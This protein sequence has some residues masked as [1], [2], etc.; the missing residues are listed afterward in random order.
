MS[1]QTEKTSKQFWERFWQKV[2][3][4]E[5]VNYSFKND[6][7]VGETLKAHIPNGA[8]N[9][10]MA[11]IG[12][13]PGKWL[14]F[15]YEK[16]SYIVTGYEYLEIAAKKTEENLLLNNVPHDKFNIIVQDFTRLKGFQKQ[17]V[18]FSTGFIEH[19][20]DYE[21]ILE[22]Q[23]D[24]LNNDGYLIIGVPSFRYVNYLIQ[25]M[26]DPY[27]SDKVLPSHN[28]SAMKKANLLKFARTHNLE[29]IFCEFLGGY[30][31]ALFNFD[32]VQHC[33]IRFTL[34]ALNALLSSRMFGFVNSSFVS[35]FLFSIFKKPTKITSNSTS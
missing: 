12:C 14:V 34:K 29:V 35:G 23:L 4:P 2:R 17:D 16:L 1:S 28:Q 7:L 5:R 18:I 20:D 21:N 30:E 25:K 22:K 6:R 15:F 32:V 8:L 3:L 10:T 24:M 13:A 19:F 33:I 31:P 27:L 9:K 26:I 11:E